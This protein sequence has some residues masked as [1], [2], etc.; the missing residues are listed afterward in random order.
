MKNNIKKIF[1]YIIIPV[2][3][4]IVYY[5]LVNLWIISYPNSYI[6]YTCEW[7][8]FSCEQNM[9]KECKS[10]KLCIN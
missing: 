1:R 6:K 3:L 7:K 5:V 9:S 8:H 4:F 10:K 2:I